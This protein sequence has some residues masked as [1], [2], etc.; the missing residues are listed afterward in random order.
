[1]NGGG[2]ASEY[3]RLGRM[4]GEMSDERLLDLWRE[5]ETLTSEAQAALTGEMR[6][7]RLEGAPGRTT[8]QDVRDL[9]VAVSARGEALSYAFGAGIAGAIPGSA[10]ALEHALELLGEKFAG[11]VQ[12]VQLRDGLELSSACDALD[13]AG[14]APAIEEIAGDATVGL[15]SSFQIWV[16]AGNEEEA[17][18]VLR[19]EL[20]LFPL[21]EADEL[22]DAE[23]ISEVTEGEVGDFETPEEAERVRALLAG[24]GFRASVEASEVLDEE[25]ISW[26]TVKVEPAEYA[27]AMEFLEERLR[28]EDPT[29]G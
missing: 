29:A 20:G 19:G 22:S 8:G 25:G 26:S 18:A 4:Y 1:M 12:L 27:R 10:L 11:M 6:H 24:A 13:H 17:K 23:A 14:I 28:L 9:N 15:T 5:S 3:D 2:M 21:A 7:R 16:D